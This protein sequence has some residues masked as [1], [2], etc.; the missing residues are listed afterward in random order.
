[1][2]MRAKKE[3]DGGCVVVVCGYSGDK[4]EPKMPHE[5]RYRYVREFF[6]D[7]DLVSVYAINDS[8]LGFPLY[9]DGWDEWLVEFKRLLDIATDGSDA[10]RIWY[11]G[12]PDYYDSLVV[13]GEKAVLLDRSENL[14]SGTMI[15]SNPLK[16]W[17]KIA[18]TF[19]R[20]F[21]LNI[22]IIGTVSEGKSTLTTDLGKYFNSLYS[23]EW[24]QNYVEERCLCPW[25]FDSTDFMSFLDG[26]YK[27]NKSLI[28]SPVSN[29]IFFA[30]SDAMTTRMYAE[31]YAKEDCCALKPEEFEVI[32]AAADEYVRKSRWDKIYLLCPKGEFV[33][34]HSRFMLHAGMEK[35]QEMYEILIKDI[36]C[37]GYWD[38]VTILDGGYLNNFDRIVSDVREM[39]GHGKD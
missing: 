7:D 28:D 34:D 5:K 20:I 36:K 22:L 9:P 16:H 12:E 1:M 31:M 38:K 25:E 8:E 23:Y 30:D 26:Q 32:A 4:G 2:I 37:N 19:R 18:G 27:L 15:R 29:G 14:I 3:N 39:L 21:S 13:R 33:D 35:R 6:R 10:E 17:D 11:V 24:A